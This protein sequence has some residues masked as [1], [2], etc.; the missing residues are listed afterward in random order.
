M[1]T[2]P[3]LR[4][5][6]SIPSTC[7]RLH[8]HHHLSS[9]SSTPQTVHRAALQ[10]AIISGCERSGLVKVELGQTL[11]D[12][13]FDATR[14]RIRPSKDTESE[15]AWIE[16]DVVLAA[17]GV[18]SFARGAMLARHGEVESVVDTGQAAYRILLTREQMGDDEELLKLIDGQ[19]SHRWI[20]HQRHIIACASLFSSSRC[21]FR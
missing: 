8:A 19:I 11:V 12:V 21:R 7:V 5:A 15:G 18:K 14:I 2:L 10:R 16:A 1:S 20:G 6:T 17:D 13:D 4:R 3:A 9:S